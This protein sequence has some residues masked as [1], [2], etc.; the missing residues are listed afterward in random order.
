MCYSEIQADINISYTRPRLNQELVC[1][2]HR[3]KKMNWIWWR[4]LSSWLSLP[5]FTSVVCVNILHWICKRQKAN[6]LF[7]V[8]KCTIQH[9]ILNIIVTARIMVNN[10]MKSLYSNLSATSSNQADKQT[11]TA[12]IL[13]KKSINFSPKYTICEFDMLPNQTNRFICLCINT[14]VNY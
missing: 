5:C 6:W 2:V 13:T 14:Q 3:T 12:L 7:P 1:A 11:T 10:L 9:C 4:Q 8:I